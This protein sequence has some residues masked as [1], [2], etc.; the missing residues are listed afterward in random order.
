MYRALKDNATRRG[1]E[2]ALTFEYFEQFCKDNNY[3]ERK[4]AGEDLTIDRIEVTKGYI[5]GNLQVLDR[6]ANT[7]KWHEEDL[8]ELCPY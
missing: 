4:Q 3:L 7:R 8:D 1:K 6:A 2:F 5:P